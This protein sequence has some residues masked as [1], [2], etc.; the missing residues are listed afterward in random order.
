MSTRSVSIS[1][2]DRPRGTLAE[3]RRASHKR[4]NEKRRAKLSTGT[5]NEDDPKTTRK[6]GKSFARSAVYK[7]DWRAKR[8]LKQQQQQIGALETE[9]R[10]L[11]AEVKQR[12]RFAA[13]KAEQNCA[14]LQD[15]LE[16]A[17]QQLTQQQQLSAQSLNY[18]GPRG[19][20]ERFARM[21]AKFMEEGA[22][23][24]NAGPM[25][26]TAAEFFT[27]RKLVSVPSPRSLGEFAR[28]AGIVGEGIVAKYI[29]KHSESNQVVALHI[30]QTTKYG[31]SLHGESVS[32]PDGKTLTFGISA[33][34]SKSTEHQLAASERLRT[35]IAESGAAVFGLKP[36]DPLQAVGAVVADAGG[37]EEKMRQLLS[38]KRNQLQQ[39]A[40]E[41]SDMRGS[42]SEQDVPDG[43][44][45]KKD[46]TSTQT[47]DDIMMLNCHKHKLSNITTAAEKNGMKKAVN[48]GQTALDLEK[49]VAK[50]FRQT[51][52]WG[53]SK[54]AEFDA[55]CKS[56]NANNDI[57]DMQP[58]K[59]TRHH[60]RFASM[61]WIVLAAP[62]LIEFLELVAQAPPPAESDLQR[63]K[64][65][66]LNRYACVLATF[67]HACALERCT[68]RSR[69]TE[70]SHRSL[71]QQRS[72][73]KCKHPAFF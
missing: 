2:P 57:K 44:D 55:F 64:A 49:L 65:N 60:M 7:R 21:C 14:T 15:A 12:E 48:G 33:T 11:R 62:L 37:V 3:R 34:P 50:G 68:R 31:V 20:D 41:T 53:H 17:Q 8:T 22:S 66:Q 18:L 56:K 28:T 47:D 26:K 51:S 36:R 59:G 1:R 63:I 29:A 25:I 70:Q 4:Y 27:D 42:E 73:A 24:S 71:R 38:E 5:T 9:V 6:R 23:E 32:L 58:S 43:K 39:Q 67:V 72:V 52:D 10:I 30:D 13:A 40:Q 69:T 61:V 19:Y 54:G 46:D 45:E 16:Q 35:D